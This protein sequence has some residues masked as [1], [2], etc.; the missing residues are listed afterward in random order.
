MSNKVEIAKQQSHYLRGTLPEEL[1]NGTD[2][3]SD[4]NE[5][6]LKFHGIA[7]RTFVYDSRRHCWRCAQP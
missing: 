3:F 1:G 4:S 5:L 7:S 6:L 2:H